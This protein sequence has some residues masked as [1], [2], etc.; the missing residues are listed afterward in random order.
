MK[1]IKPNKITATQKQKMI[2]KEEVTPE[3]AFTKM[4]VIATRT[5][6]KYQLKSFKLDSK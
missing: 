6:S 4:T 3:N 2:L 1:K 5:A